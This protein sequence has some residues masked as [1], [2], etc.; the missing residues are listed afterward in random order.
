MIRLIKRYLKGT[1]RFWAVLAPLMMLLEVLMDLQQPTLMANI[2]DVG[3][4]GRNLPHVLT[5]G[6][7]MM[8][9]AVLGLI[10]GAGCS[11]FASLA[12]VNMSAR[13]RQ[14]LFDKIQSLSFAE[15][16][17]FKTS[18]LITRLTNDVAQVQTMM[19]MMLRIMVRSPLIC[20]G[21][22]LM[23]VL[24]I[25]QFATVFIIVLPLIVCGIVIVLKQSMPL[26]MKVQERIDKLNTV[27]RENLLGVRV[28]KT[29]GIEGRQFQRFSGIND[30]LAQQSI[31]AQ[32][33]TFTLMPMVTLVMNLSVVAVLWSGGNWVVA[34][35]LQLG[36]IMAFINYL[37]QIS[38]SL[39]MLV[40]L[41][42]NISRA[43]ASAARINEVLETEPSLVQPDPAETMAGTA[44][45]FQNVS[46]RYSRSGAAVLKNISFRI[47]PG[48]TVGI[49]GAT[50]SGKS[51]LISLIPRLYDA[52]EGKVL[53][54][55][56]DVRRI[57]L[58]SL[59]RKIGIVLQNSILFSGTIGDNLRFGNQ[60]A[61]TAELL[62]AVADAQ[63]DFV[64]GLP[65]QFDSPVEQR[66]RNFSGGQ[67][68]R[69]SI[70]RT[71]L[72]Q[73]EILILDD[74]TSA[75]DLATEARL[76]SSLAARMQGRTVLII[77]QR[78]S[79]IKNADKI[80]VLDHGRLVAEGR[81]D[82]LIKTSP[83]Y[84]SI[85]RSQLGEEALRDAAC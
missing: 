59:R 80:L 41:A 77:A 32:G 3:V 50:G 4:A 69:L 29:F 21:S 62:Q 49:I 6:G 19:L 40:N 75:L 13:L 60:Q 67:K 24:L 38:H 79:A 8:L 9:F 46:L 81:H 2:I 73:P 68:Q 56:V 33:R 35:Q 48:Q 34:G 12:A 72:C 57:S 23:S 45:E 39:M 42:V 66:G 26:F 47:E 55:G 30:D 5:V 63:A 10:G 76:R 52:T 28:V 7:K 31:K 74:A 43:Q 51:T 36:K 25:P 70:A 64:T 27:M 1:A 61:E 44:I 85:V 84:R 20:L 83:V 16:D 53:I 82:E 78:I 58:A 17:N 54:G 14:G 15:I 22:I 18:T 71:L 65:Q 11:V 37:I